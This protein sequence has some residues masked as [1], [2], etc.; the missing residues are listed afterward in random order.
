MAKTKK[1]LVISGGGA[2]GAYGAGT[3]AALN[4]DYD[5]VVGISTGALMAP[6]V[7]LKQWD[8]LKEA[9]TSVNQNDIIDR[10][11][12]KPAPFTKKGK[13]NILALI[14]AIICGKPTLATSNN[15]KKLI[16][17]FLC[18]EDFQLLKDQGK[19]VIVGCQNL[20]QNPSKVHYFNSAN[21][22]FEDFKDWTWFSAN[23]PFILSLVHKEWAD[24]NGVKHMGQWTD[25]GLTEVVPVR[26][27][28]KAECN[29]IDI[30]IHR[31][32]PKDILEVDSIKN[33]VENVTASIEAMRFDIE[34][35]NLV[36]GAKAYAKHKRAVVTLY[37]LPR[38]LTNNS[39]MFDKKEMTEWWNEGF[40][41]A[42]DEKRIIKFN[43]QVPAAAARGKKIIRP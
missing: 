9:Y 35:E 30:I 39:L 15:L 21:C 13:I 1:G 28:Y 10:K 23:A 11:W 25:G 12:Y 19:E 37:F 4:K 31:E 27:L 16:N 36:E 26:E 17:Q 14:Y 5:K 40:A 43:G 20:K 29:E 3:L 6:L 2:L 38:K 32:I 7:A 24:E 18:E 33:G 41:T 42:F 22:E 8:K 34:F